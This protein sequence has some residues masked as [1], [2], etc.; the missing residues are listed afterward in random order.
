MP[1]YFPDLKSVQR[2][3]KDMAEQSDDNKKYRGIIPQN[4]EELE[5][6]REQ[7]GEYL[8]EV[9]NDNIFALEVELA[10]TPED[11]DEKMRKHVLMEMHRDMLA[12]QEIRG[13]KVLSSL[14]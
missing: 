4:E 7:L 5:D 8:R 11:Y 14:T 1:M 13:M 10:V 2:L 6:A 12:R 9:W 3:A